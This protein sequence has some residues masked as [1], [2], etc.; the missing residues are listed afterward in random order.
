MKTKILIIEDN[1]LIQAAY[2]RAFGLLSDME[3]VGSALNGEEGFALLQKLDPDIIICDL[4]MPVM[5]G[6]EFTKKAMAEKPKPILIISDLVQKEDEGNIFKVL[7]LGAL[8]VLPKPRLGGDIQL[9]AEELARKIR[10]LKNVIVFR[11]V[12]DRPVVK[13]SEPV[14]SKS[15]HT[16]FEILVI[17]ASTGGPQAFQTVLSGIPKNFPLPILC[18]QH[19]SPGF[20]ESL[21]QWLRHSCPCPVQFGVSGKKPEAGVI[22][23][24]PDDSHLTIKG[25]FISIN[26]NEP[27]RGHRPSVDTLFHS[28]VTEF[29]DKALAI[30]LT[31]MGDDGARGLKALRDSGSFTVAQ[32]ELSSIV[33]GMPRVAKEMDAPLEVLS[34]DQIS[35]RILNLVGV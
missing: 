27:E 35:S 28:V 23:F 31:G 18:V 17:G 21:L 29:G 24:P 33:Y 12:Q 5:D 13:I 34:L 14:V 25:G 3:V 20:S 15:H 9:I 10:V 2:K 6:F 26:Q 30:L 7:N 4:N 1:Q 16:K 19:I 22:Y 32:D 11:K 8:D